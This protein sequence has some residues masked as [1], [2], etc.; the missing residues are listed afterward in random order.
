MLFSRPSW[1]RPGLSQPVYFA[2]C[3]LRRAQACARTRARTRTRAHAALS[4]G[5]NTVVAAYALMPSLPPNTPIF[6]PARTHA[7][8]WSPPPP[9]PPG[10][11]LRTLTT[12]RSAAL[13]EG[14]TLAT[15]RAPRPSLLAS[16]QRHPT[17]G[18][19]CC[20]RRTF[21]QARQLRTRARKRARSCRDRHCAPARKALATTKRIA[22]MAPTPNVRTT[23]LLWH[24]H[25]SRA[26]STPAQWQH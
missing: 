14:F 13:M 16:R 1:E 4:A 18:R 9:P 6:A 19:W 5:P 11:C 17:T 26:R 24:T 7:R 12:L 21:C 3:L 8:T 2:T 10:T 22:L 25:A 23:L 15:A 20:L